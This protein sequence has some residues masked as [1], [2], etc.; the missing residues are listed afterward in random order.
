MTDIFNDLQEKDFNIVLKI[1]NWPLHDNQT[2]YDLK[3]TTFSACYYC[4]FMHYFYLHSF[5]LKNY[6]NVAEKFQLFDLNSYKYYYGFRYMNG[7]FA[8]DNQFSEQVHEYFKTH[9]DC[10]TLAPGLLDK[11]LM[12]YLYI[13]TQQINTY[14]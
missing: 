1:E 2:M 12:Q 6:S 10:F 14:M 13:K 9:N 4:N 5:R 7:N 3:Y 11:H 8:V